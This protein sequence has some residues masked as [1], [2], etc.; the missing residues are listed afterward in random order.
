MERVEPIIDV[1]ID[2]RYPIILADLDLF[3]NVWKNT[4]KPICAKVHPNNVTNN[5]NG[6]V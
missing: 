3:K 6:S 4:A 5:N 1:H 2:I